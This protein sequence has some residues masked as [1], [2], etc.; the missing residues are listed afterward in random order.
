MRK[1]TVNN[2][3]AS[4]EQ[5]QKVVK[6]ASKLDNQYREMELTVYAESIVDGLLKAKDTENYIYSL[7][8]YLAGILDAP[9]IFKEFGIDL[10]AKL[11]DG[12]IESKEITE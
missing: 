4:D 9:K 5:F 7:N 10:F 8:S 12:S 3:L 1:G 11:V 6:D 2:L